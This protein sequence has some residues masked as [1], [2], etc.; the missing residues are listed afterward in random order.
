MNKYYV[1]MHGLEVYVTI[2]DDRYIVREKVD[3]MMPVASCIVWIPI[4]IWYRH[5]IRIAMLLVIVCSLPD[6]FQAVPHGS[7][8]WQEYDFL[9]FPDDI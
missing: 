5:H 8:I 4:S 9:F 1:R 6:A 7:L 2:I 3:L